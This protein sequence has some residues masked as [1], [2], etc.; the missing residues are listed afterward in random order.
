[1]LDSLPNPRVGI[2][3]RH[4]EFGTLRDIAQIGDEG[5]A[6]LTGSKVL[7]LFLAASIVNHVRQVPL[8]LSTSHDSL[9]HGTKQVSYTTALVVTFA[10]FLNIP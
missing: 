5:D 9:S 10:I 4:Q 6:D 3:H 1:M 7:L 2:F 8:K